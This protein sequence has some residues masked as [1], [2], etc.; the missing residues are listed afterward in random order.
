MPKDDRAHDPSQ[1]RPRV[2][3]VGGGFAGYH[4]TRALARTMGDAAEI[5]LV[6]PT[7]YFLYLPLLPEVAAGILEP[8][9]ISISLADALPA[10][11]RTMPGEVDE[12]D[13]AGR[14]VRWVDPEGGRQAITYDRL[15]L[16]AGSV[17][18]L[19]PVP[20]VSDHAH[21]FRGIP[22]ALYLRDHLIRQIDLAAAT[23]D[24]AEQEAR[25][26]FVVVGAGYTGTELAAQGQ[27]F[28][29]LLA[30]SRGMPERSTRWVLVNRSRILSGLD[31]HLA[32]TA[33]R[34]LRERGVDVR[35]GTTV[36]EATA[37]GVRLDTGEHV[38]TRTL[39]W[40]VGVRADP[41]LASLGLEL[42]KGRVVVGPD[43]RAP[44]HPEVFVCGD[45]AAVP[46]P[47]RPGQLTAM[48]AQHAVRQGRLAARNVAASLAGRRMR[49]Y[50]HRDLGFVVDLGGTQAAANPLHIPLS[51]RPAK[52]LARGYHL[53]SMP[54]NRVRTAVDWLLDAVLPRQ[55]SQLGVVRS[56]AVPLDTSSP[57]VP[58]S[59][60]GFPPADP[61]PVRERAA[62]EER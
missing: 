51:G 10:Q 20:G 12:I 2:V 9:R 36:E 6:S 13:L 7:N 35:T 4:A 57:E 15:V 26:T 58:Q 14:T 32:D 38:P 54:G 17:H 56:D 37:T 41:L 21:G 45:A 18:M 30:R 61:P 55:T 39:L 50:R 59:P 29:D 23:G 11:V 28:T 47:G 33:D 1:Q 24:P 40:C 60:L 48:T 43:L 8:R 19:Q 44:G 5:V 27:L 53:M 52:A 34:V 22:E 49:R 25:R 16:A 42:E 3:V 31:Q 46:D 62:A